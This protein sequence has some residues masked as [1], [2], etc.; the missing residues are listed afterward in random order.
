MKK[1]KNKSSISLFCI[2][3]LPV[4]AL[5]VI[6]FGIMYTGK[7][8]SSSM[9][10]TIKTNSIVFANKLSYVKKEP[11]R[12]DIILFKSDEADERVVCKRII[13]IPGD[14]IEFKNGY[15]Y[16]NGAQCEESYLNPAVETNCN[17]TFMV[18]E[19]SYFV[20]G[21]NRENSFDS[22]MYNNPYIL[23]SSIIGKLCGKIL[24]KE[25]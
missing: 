3:I 14:N 5:F 25:I 12:G 1:S 8:G 23:K 20:L 11:Q 17:K 2:Y 9:S 16:I 18:P 13:G 7:V 4:L 10:P 22:R 21:D 24:L 19:G 6:F 15:V